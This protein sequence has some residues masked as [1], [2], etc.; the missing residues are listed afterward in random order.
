M[1]SQSAG[2]VIFKNFKTKQARALFAGIA[3]HS[4]MPLDKP[5]SAAFGLLLGAA[6]HV[7]GWPIAKGG[8]QNIAAA[9]QKYFI[10][11]GGEIKTGIEIQLSG[12]ITASQSRT[13]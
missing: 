12:R 11:L 7:G 1:A 9:L 13:T 4:K 3:A 5:G 2:Y 8:S 6:G 10:A